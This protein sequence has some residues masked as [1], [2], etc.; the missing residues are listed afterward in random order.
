MA[1]DDDD[2]GPG[3]LTTALLLAIAAGGAWFVWRTLASSAAAS[4]ST[5]SGS[6]TDTGSGGLL[7]SL[8]LNS[9]FGSVLPR[10]VRNNNPGNIKYNPAND[11]DGQTGSDA[12]GFA[13]FSDPTYGLRA[14]FLTLQSY[15][16]EIS[17]FNIQLIG[18]RWTSGDPSA[19]LAN[20]VNT[21]SS[22]SGYPSTQ[23]LDPNDAT[24]MQNLV[25]GIVAAENG[26][27]ATMLYGGSLL[28][29]AH[30]MAV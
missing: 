13:I 23:I 24:Q 7:S 16:G 8:N 3:F 25:L 26:Q 20:W 10:G 18:A 28:V 6:S 19:T 17:P 1:A 30:Q 2:G 15:S 5:S 14:M 4:T 9:L 29:Q 22:V 21:V 11:W 27:P 12:D